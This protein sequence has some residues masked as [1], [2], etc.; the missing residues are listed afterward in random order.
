MAV[1][2][3]GT[4]GI[5]FNNGS[6][7]AISGGMGTGATAQTWQNVTASRANGVTYTNSTGYP[8]QLSIVQGVGATTALNLS[9]N[10]TSISGWSATTQVSG[11]GFFVIIPNGATYQMTNSASVL[12]AWF[13]LR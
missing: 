4:D 2:I 13:E 8:I 9:V 3:N 5:T 12:N 7:Q 6:T 10:G 11:Q 1:T